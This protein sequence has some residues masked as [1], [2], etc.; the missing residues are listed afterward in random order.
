MTWP[1][2]MV[3]QY[4]ACMVKRTSRP[5]KG[6]QSNKCFCFSSTSFNEC[7]FHQQPCYC[8]RQR[9]TNCPSSGTSNQSSKNTGHQN[10]LCGRI[11][12]CQNS[13]SKQRSARQGNNTV[14]IWVPNYL[15]FWF[16]MVWCSNGWSMWYVLCTRTTIWILDQFKTRWRLFVWYSNV[17]WISDHLASDLS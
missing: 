11:Q 5:F 17:I 9:T 15:K 2:W 6:S 12:F 14:G 8:I 1:D 4:I 16:Q 10:G 3:S 7:F 13:K